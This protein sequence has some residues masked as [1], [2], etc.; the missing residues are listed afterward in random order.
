MIGLLDFFALR[1]LKLERHDKL[2]RHQQARYPA[3]EL[4]LNGWLD[5]YQGYQSRPVFRQAKRVIAFAGGDGTTATLFGVF[6]VKGVRPAAAGPLPRGCLYASQ[7]QRECRY[8]YDLA[9]LTD[10]RDFNGR[11]VIDWGRATRSWHQRPSNKPVR[12]LL[13][14]GRLLPRFEGYLSFSLTYPEL[15]HLIE[16]SSAHPDW[17]GPLSAV[18]GIYLIVAESTGQQY[19]DSASGKGGIWQRWQDYVSSGHGGNAALK[20]LVAGDNANFPRGFRFSVLHT[21]PSGTA[22]AKVAAIESLHKVKLG[23][24]VIGLNRN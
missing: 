24:R 8:F 16:N 7:W 17:E 10:Y 15:R 23:S 14:E 11:L 3:R 1:G 22:P 13:P 5:V 18:G 2:V 21:F 9:E 6:D 4:L 20:I 19:I 12:E